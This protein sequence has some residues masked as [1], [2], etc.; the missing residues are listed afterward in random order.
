MIAPL[1]SLFISDN[2]GADLNTVWSMSTSRS[3]KLM[4]D[5]MHCT[6]HAEETLYYFHSLQ[7]LVY[8][9]DILCVLAYYNLVFTV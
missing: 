3:S 7:T 2:M 6:T 8:I 5:A 9:S 1:R 4:I